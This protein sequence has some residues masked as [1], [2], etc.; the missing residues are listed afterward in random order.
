VLH[1]RYLLGNLSNVVNKLAVLQ[2]V[3]G[4]VKKK[5]LITT[6]YEPNR[7]A[8]NHLVDTYE[9]L[10]PKDKYKMSA[11][12]S[13]EMDIDIQVMFHNLQQGNAK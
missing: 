12:K 4:N 3:K 2:G 10:F 11:N 7:L 9:K 1:Q 6:T 13:K 5:W 8:S